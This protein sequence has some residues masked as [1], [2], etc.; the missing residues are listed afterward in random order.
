MAS[1]NQ[2]L[3]Q[4]NGDSWNGILP[5][6]LGGAYE[7]EYRRTVEP[8]PPQPTADETEQALAAHEYSD[9][10]VRSF[11]L[12]SLIGVNEGGDLSHSLNVAKQLLYNAHV[13]ARGL[14]TESPISDEATELYDRYRSVYEP[15]D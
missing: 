9:G 11:R 5:S 13:A 10:E 12:L 7:E 1:R 2:K 3:P 15:Q 8:L 6:G 4:W 14:P